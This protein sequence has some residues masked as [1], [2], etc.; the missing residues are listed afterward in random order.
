MSNALEALR[1][2]RHDLGK[3]IAFQVRWL[4][5]DCSDADLREALVADLRETR[6]GPDG[7]ETAWDVW[8]RLRPALA[9]AKVELST[10]DE[11]MGT[12]QSALAGLD[13][14]SRS[15]LDAVH[16]VAIDVAKILK[17]MARAAKT[18][19]ER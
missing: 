3:Y 15:E 5:P 2:A 14:A 9:A 10:L 17:D 19:T 11:R 12:I 7:V 6:R 13:G 1:T 8:A 18:S 16:A 4:A